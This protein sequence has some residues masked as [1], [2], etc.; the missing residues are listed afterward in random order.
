MFFASRHTSDAAVRVF[1]YPLQLMMIPTEP[2]REYFLPASQSIEP[3]PRRSSWSSPNDLDAKHGDGDADPENDGRDSNSY[4]G[5][6]C[7][8]KNL[9]FSQFTSIGRFL[10]CF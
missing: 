3:I 9:C 7:G 6:D 10:V 4:C 5:G 1:L 8:G 2:Y